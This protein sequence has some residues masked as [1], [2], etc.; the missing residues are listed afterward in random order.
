M[1]KNAHDGGGIFDGESFYKGGF[2]G[3]ADGPVDV[4]HDWNYVSFYGSVK[5]IESFD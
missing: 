1:R 2:G 3:G 5:I 4:L